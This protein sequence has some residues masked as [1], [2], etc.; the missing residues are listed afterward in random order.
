[1]VPLYTQAV[2]FAK[3]ESAVREIQVITCTNYPLSSIRH[4]N[5]KRKLVQQYWKIRYKS[6]LL[7]TKHTSLTKITV[8]ALIAHEIEQ[9]KDGT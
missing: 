3:T 2:I 7:K 6:C 5:I 8:D 4:E 9:S 1:M